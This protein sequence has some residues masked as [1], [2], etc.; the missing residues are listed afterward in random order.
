[1]N[2]TR[3]RTWLLLAAALLWFSE[4]TRD[5]FGQTNQVTDLGN[6]RELFIDDHLTGEMKNV[7][8]RTKTIRHESFRFTLQ[9]LTSQDATHVC[10]AI[11][12]EWTDSL[13][14]TPGCR[15]AN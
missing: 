2:S 12:C 4:E 3:S 8:N 7:R 6:Q 11:H 15:K 14:F 9:S 10:G 13:R 1:M 5:A